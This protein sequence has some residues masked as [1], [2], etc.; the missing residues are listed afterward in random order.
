MLLAQAFGISEHVLGTLGDLLLLDIIQQTSADTVFYRVEGP[1]NA[2]VSGY[3]A[4]PRLPAGVALDDGDW[5]F[6]YGPHRGRRMRVVALRT[7]IEGR[8]LT[9]IPAYRG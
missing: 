9:G 5:H 7:L 6:F 2:F 3:S 8:E 1:A 4:L